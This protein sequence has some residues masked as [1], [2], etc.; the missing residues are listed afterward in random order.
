MRFETAYINEIGRRASNQDSLFLAR[1]EGGRG[2]FFCAAVCDGMGGLASGAEASAEMASAIDRWFGSAGEAAGIRVGEAEKGLRLAVLAV[3]EELDR[4]GRR[5]RRP[6]GTTCAALI[7]GGGSWAALCVGDTRIY[8]IRRGRGKILTRDQTLAE[9]LV[10][11]G[12]MDPAE[13]EGSR[14]SSVLL[15]CVGAS[16]SVELQRLRGRIRPGDCFLLCSDGFRRRLDTE[17]IAAAVT[18]AESGRRGLA[19][20]LRR[21]A[22][23]AWAR[24]ESD[25]MTA[26]AVR[27]L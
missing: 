4:R 26:A 15:Q 23:T 6:L 21:L 3:N 2:S 24:G 19:A 8:R 17:E 20:S 25:N 13:A 5:R 10:A 12:R 9:H 11:Q 22:G 1:S 27:C 18:A 16:P 14:E 7:G